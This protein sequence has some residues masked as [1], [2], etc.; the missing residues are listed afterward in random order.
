MTEYAFIS[1]LHLDPSRPGATKA[2][3]RFLRGDAC[4]AHRLFI[5]GDLFE[6]WIGDD[7]DDDLAN[8][9]LGALKNYT[10]TGRECL[11]MRG[12]R[13]FLLG[14]RFE[15]RTG[16]RLLED[17][18]VQDIFGVRVLVTHGDLLC[19]DDK[20]YQRYRRLVSNRFLQRV[21]LSLPRSWRRMAAAEGR[22]RSR[23][24]AAA[25]PPHIMD[26]SQDA[27]L[28]ALARFRVDVILHGHT[29]RPGIHHFR[30]RDTTATR[31]VLGDWYEQASVLAWSDSGYRLRTL[32]FD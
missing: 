23:N 28:S 6:F 22:R 27:V 14:R 12:N 11:V 21:F 8:D 24:H 31:I 7:N 2:F 29:H 25:S 9:V 15:Q 10:A 19:T 5:L 4:L 1:D 3:L 18:V 30:I 32:P 20:T 17:P 26:V 16:A 13:D